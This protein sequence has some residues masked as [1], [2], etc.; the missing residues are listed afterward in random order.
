MAM[1]LDVVSKE[2]LALAVVVHDNHKQ[3]PHA[4]VRN[5]GKYNFISL[6]ILS[7]AQIVAFILPSPFFIKCHEGKSERLLFSFWS[8]MT[9]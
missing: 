1:L 2:L 8:L 9:L 6:F 3:P 4:I 5:S 7:K